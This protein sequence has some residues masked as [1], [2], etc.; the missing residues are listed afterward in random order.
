MV[1]EL[2]EVGEIPSVG[3]VPSRMH[4]QLVRPD[5]YGEPEKA[6]QDEDC[7]GYREAYDLLLELKSRQAD[8][9]LRRALLSKLESAAPAGAPT[10]RLRVF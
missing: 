2:Y 5:R 6:I 8:L 4:A 3:H 1:K 7:G 9:D 10:R